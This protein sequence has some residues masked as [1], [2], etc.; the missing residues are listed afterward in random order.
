MIYKEAE[1]TDSDVCEYCGSKV[2]YREFID[3]SDGWEFL[4]R[5][6]DCG[7]GVY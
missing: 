3:A 2:M 7:I 5:E 6:C 4:E 1:Y